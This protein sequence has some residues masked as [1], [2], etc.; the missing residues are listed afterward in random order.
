MSNITHH[1]LYPNYPRYSLHPPKLSSLTPIYPSQGIDIV[2][3]STNGAKLAYYL[4][5]E[6]IFII[7]YL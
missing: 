2:S 3:H 4:Q 7:Q 1:P 6:T 5:N